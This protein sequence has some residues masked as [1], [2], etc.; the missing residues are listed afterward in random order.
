[1]K[2]Q[3]ISFEVSI[4]DSMEELLHKEK[5]LMQFAIGAREKAYAPYSGFRVGSAVLLENGKI[6]TGN[7]QEN[8]AYPSGLCAERVA[9]FYAGAKYPGVTIKKIAI[10][11]ASEKSIVDKPVAPCGSCR[12]AISEYEIKQ[13]SSISLLFMGEQGK[14]IQCNAMADILPLAFSSNNL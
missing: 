12:Q 8:A 5:K 3:K 9:L 14:V 1:M 2:K 4:Y 10:T 13:E 11:A 7:N 6:V